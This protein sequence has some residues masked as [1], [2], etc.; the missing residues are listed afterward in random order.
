MSCSV[1]HDVV[2]PVGLELLLSA[3]GRPFMLHA[4]ASHSLL[5]GSGGPLRRLDYEAALRAGSLTAWDVGVTP[6]LRASGRQ[7]IGEAPGWNRHQLGLGLRF[8]RY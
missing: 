3:R 5:L 2:L 7:W 4:E 8:E 1:G 6:E